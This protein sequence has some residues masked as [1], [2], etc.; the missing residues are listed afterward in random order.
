MRNECN[1]IRDILPLYVEDMVSTDTSAFV[2]GHLGKCAE[3][4][5]ELE[6]LKKPNRLEQVCNSSNDNFEDVLPLKT[7]KKKW[8]KHLGMIIIYFIPAVL[9]V[10]ASLFYLLLGVL[11]AF[12]AIDPAVWFFVALLIVSAVFMSKGK[13]WGSLGGIIVGLV[14]I[15]MSAQYTGQVIDIERPLGIGFLVY[16]LICGILLYRKEKDDS[17]AV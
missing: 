6:N 11:G 3:C 17:S 4:C 15:Y 13:W 14:L 10:I 5:A 7:L 12:G 9:A 8:Y 16:Y 2:E 1:I